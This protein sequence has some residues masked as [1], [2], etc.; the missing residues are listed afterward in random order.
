VLEEANA[1]KSAV[2]LRSSCQEQGIIR[3]HGGQTNTM[4]IRS[5][6]S[7]SAV[8]TILL[9]MAC[10]GGSHPPSGWNQVTGPGPSPRWTHAAVLD[11]TRRNAVVFGGFGAGNEVWLF[12]FAARS[13][14]RVNAPNGPSPRASPAAVSDPGGDRMVMVG[15]LTSAPTDEVWAFSF[16]TKTW[17]SLPKGPSPR[18]DMGAATDGTHAWF[19]GG[20]LAGSKATDE[21]WQFDLAS[22]TWTLLPQSQ[23][24]PSPRTNMGIGFNAGSLYVIGGHDATGLTSGTWRYDFASSAWMQLSPAGTPDAGA[25]FASATD[26]TCGVL[27]LAGGDHD[28]GVDVNTTDVFSFASPSFTRLPATTNFS[29]SR[30]HSVLVLEPQSRTLMLFGGLHDPSQLLG[31]TWTYQLNGCAQ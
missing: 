31:D 30:R 7:V 2:K 18:F 17:S 29:P 19:Y 27:L 28:D 4:F 22:N 1:V 14:T 5:A 25:H 11:S 10:G 8:C 24:R 20:F 6:V 13:W 12:S 23:L 9:F 16:A 15:G 26:S 21:L 3:E